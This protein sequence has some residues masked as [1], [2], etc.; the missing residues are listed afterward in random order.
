MVF[1]FLF[2]TKNSSTPFVTDKDDDSITKYKF[3]HYI[4]IYVLLNSNIYGIYG[5]LFVIKI[6][7][8]EEN[9]RR[10]SVSVLY[11]RKVHRNAQI[12]PLFNDKENMN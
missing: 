8:S 5:R 10:P 2:L 1:I 6:N 9:T 4:T 12:I 11:F 7:L 3:C